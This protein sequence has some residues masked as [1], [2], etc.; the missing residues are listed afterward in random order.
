MLN[1]FDKLMARGLARAKTFLGQPV[2]IGVHVDV[3]AAAVS[4]IRREERFDT[5]GNQVWVDVGDIGIAREDWPEN[6]PDPR[7]GEVVTL[8]NG[9]RYRVGRVTGT[10]ALLSV[11][12][13]SLY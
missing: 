2:A 4:P 8:A 11:E 6:Q 1:A 10:D 5:K 12:F 3:P 9:R 7:S 13:T